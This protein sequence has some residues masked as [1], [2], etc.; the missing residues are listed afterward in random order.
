M[1][2][3]RFF[4]CLFSFSL[5]DPVVLDVEDLLSHAPRSDVEAARDLLMTLR[6]ARENSYRLAQEE[7]AR[8]LPESVYQHPDVLQARTLRSDK[9]VFPIGD[10]AAAK[11]W[12]HI[13]QTFA[14]GSRP[15][16]YPEDGFWVDA[17]TPPE[18]SD[19]AVL[20]S[21]AA[22]VLNQDG[23]EVYYCRKMWLRWS[24][25]TPVMVAKWT[26]RC[27]RDLVVFDEAEQP[28]AVG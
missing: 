20:G 7:A 6:E 1:N 24:D 19:P 10:I 2:L 28:A 16:A 21:Q 27:N 4:R 25:D 11:A 18:D 13:G 15:G 9:A 3:R 8:Q 23:E 22:P 14:E 17:Q 26:R 12:A 5:V